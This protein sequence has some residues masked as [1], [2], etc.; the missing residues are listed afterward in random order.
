MIRQKLSDFK[1]VA[2][3]TNISNAFEADYLQG[4]TFADLSSYHRHIL[5]G[6]SVI[7]MLGILFTNVTVIICL[8]KTNQTN[9]LSFRIILHLSF[10][11]VLLGLVGV[12]T[13]IFGTIIK[14][15]SLVLQFASLCFIALFSHVSI[16]ITGLIGVDRFVRINYYTKHREILTPFRVFM[17]QILIW[18]LALLNT[19]LIL[20]DVLNQTAVFRIVVGLCDVSL[21]ILVAVLQIKTISSMKTLL[22]LTESSLDQK[23]RKLAT[24]ILIAITLL[25]PPCVV[26]AIVRG[27]IE[28]TL[29]DKGRGNLQFI[30]G[31]A[32]NLVYVNSCINA[33]LFL[34][35][36][37]KSKKYLRSFLKGKARR[38]VQKEPTESTQN[39]SLRLQFHQNTKLQTVQSLHKK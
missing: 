14:S 33:V 9:N 10:S 24:K 38:S 5:I 36:N 15:S 20:L 31:M 37:V 19:V 28:G 3:Y 8:C 17:V 22:V 2:N 13:F 29:T 6:I 27:N 25:L 18:W 30:F 32:I 34:A 26:C 21:I 12:P 1:E 7:I 16:Y 39:M 4:V 23:I 35:S 11:D